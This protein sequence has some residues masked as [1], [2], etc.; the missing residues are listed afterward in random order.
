MALPIATDAALAKINE[1]P[2][3]LLT[4]SHDWVKVFQLMPTAEK[5]NDGDEYPEILRRMI[6]TYSDTRSSPVMCSD[7]EKV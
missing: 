1:H 5:G 3:L 6:G 4:S 7:R 2:S